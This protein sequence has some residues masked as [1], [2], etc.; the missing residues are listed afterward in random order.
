MVIVP[1]C[2]TFLQLFLHRERQLIPL[3]EITVM[4]PEYRCALPCTITTQDL[5]SWQAVTAAAAT[6]KPLILGVASPLRYS[7]YSASTCSA[8][9]A[10]CRL[11]SAS[12]R[13]IWLTT[14]VNMLTRMAERT[15]GLTLSAMFFALVIFVY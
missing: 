5:S 4:Q 12:T 9:G 2:L 14:I 13:G 6:E 8:A 10:I 15:M 11:S 3:L 1:G 7:Q